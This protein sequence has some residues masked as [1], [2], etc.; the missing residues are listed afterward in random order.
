[1]IVISISG[2][3][4]YSYCHF[5]CYKCQTL[6]CLSLCSVPPVHF[7]AIAI[8]SDGMPVTLNE[9]ANG[10]GG[11]VEVCVVKRSGSV[12]AT[13]LTVELLFNAIGN[14]PRAGV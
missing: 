9:N 12:S 2:G 6:S 10:S 11:S 4:L 14:L 1:M 8:R 7:S 3:V 5:S 13:G